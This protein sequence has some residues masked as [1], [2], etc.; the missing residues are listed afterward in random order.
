MSLSLGGISRTVYLP[1][2]MT[3]MM[4]PRSMR[5]TGGAYAE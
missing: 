2:H 1:G 3:S 5:P 4:L